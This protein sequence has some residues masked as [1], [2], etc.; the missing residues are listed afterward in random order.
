MTNPINVPIPQE[1]I[2]DYVDQLIAAS[3]LF[4][5]SRMGNAA[6]ERADHVM[7]MVKSFRGTVVPNDRTG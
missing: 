6:L 1:W 2:R 3:K 7:D 4:G 5:D